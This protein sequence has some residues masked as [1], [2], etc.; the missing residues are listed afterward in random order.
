MTTS[1]D[2]EHLRAPGGSIPL[3]WPSAG[4]S[5]FGFVAPKSADA[6]SLICDAG[7]G[8]LLTIAP[9]RRGKGRSAIMPA[10]L[11]Y[12]GP[13]IV[14]DPKGESYPVTARR[15]R[16]LGQTVKVLDP[17]HVVTETS[18]RLD[19]LDL[20]DLPKGMLDCDSEMLAAQFSLGH[21]FESDSYW[22][23][24]ARSLVAGLIALLACT[25][26]R[27]ERTLPAVRKL[28]YQDDLDYFLAVTLDTRK[29]LPAF[30]RDLTA[31][32]L[33]IPSDKTRPCVRSSAET[34]LSVLGSAAVSTVLQ[35]S[36]VS[37][38]DI[39]YGRPMTLYIVIPPDKLD[40]HAAL[41][42]IWLATL[43]TVVGRRTEIP[44]APTLFLIDEA[45]QLGEMPAL[46]TA[47]T[48]LRGSGLR[49]WSFWQDLS[50]LQANFP[51]DWSTIVNN[52]SV[53]QLF[54][55][56]HP[57]LARQW[58]DLLDI[59]PRAVLDL[60]DD[61]QLVFQPDHGLRRLRKCDYLRDALFA[62]LF[63]PNPRYGRID[64]GC[65]SVTQSPQG[66]PDHVPSRRQPTSDR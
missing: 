35:D 33:Q 66:T 1:D 54:G 21:T 53:L 64:A 18:D 20:L 40:S 47:I 50:Q 14:F 8:H 49:I 7:D 28:F 51:K 17:F 57:F 11:T 32:Y 27:T 56:R 6:T 52:C 37:L 59:D 30:P 45:A 9:T 3:G 61:E 41:L 43:L 58:A 12:E 5:H 60:A 16:E 19:P 13:V 34:F 26:P 25:K 42:R 36:T 38:Q 62:G 46:K 23:D 39:L 10:L 55:L 4:G 31:N 2:T 44:T 63:D 29:D 22:N 15:R 65:L 48:L 24:T